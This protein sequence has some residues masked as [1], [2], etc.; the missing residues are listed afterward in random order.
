[1]TT[2]VVEIIVKKG[3]C[4]RPEARPG[5]QVRGSPLIWSLHPG[6]AVGRRVQL[7]G[8]PPKLTWR[9]ASAR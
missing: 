5:G 4:C 6:N 1:M 7:R 3:A 2:A 9:K 8:S